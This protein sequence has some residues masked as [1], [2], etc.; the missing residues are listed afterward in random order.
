[1]IISVQKTHYSRA[2]VVE[3]RDGAGQGVG[4]IWPTFLPGFLPP[5]IALWNTE[6]L[7]THLKTFG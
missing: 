4:L 7:G 6:L 2:A 1:M 5:Q 3:K